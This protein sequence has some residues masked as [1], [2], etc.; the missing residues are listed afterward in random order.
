MTNL[1]VDIPYTRFDKKITVIFKFHELRMF[2]FRIFF[3]SVMLVHMSV[4]YVEDISH[5]ELSVFDRQKSL[6]LF[7][8]ALRFVTIRK[9]LSKKLY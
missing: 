7:W 4:K 5:L 3:F 9:N 6:V 8:S 2:N 1:I